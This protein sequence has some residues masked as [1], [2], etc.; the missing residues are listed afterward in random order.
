[1]TWSEIKKA[2]EQAGI[3][4][5]DEISVIQCET[6]HGAKRFHIL[7]L[8]RFIRLVEDFSESARSE[9]SGCTC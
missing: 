6:R 7:K 4:E 3:N 2:A 8:G 9:A 1:M 5:E